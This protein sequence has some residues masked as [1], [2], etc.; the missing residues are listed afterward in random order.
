M[1]SV[2]TVTQ[3]R[4]VAKPEILDPELLLT[5]KSNSL[6][7]LALKI[8]YRAKTVPDFTERKSYNPKC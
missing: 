4:D 1:S 5:W 3:S 2:D 6:L 7:P 8:L